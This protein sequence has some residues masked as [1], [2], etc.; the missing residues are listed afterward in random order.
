MPASRATLALMRL[1]FLSVRAIW[2]MPNSMAWLR[3]QQD[4][5]PGSTWR[6]YLIALLI[7]GVASAIRMAFFADLG[8]NTAYLTYYPA[9]VLAALAGGL[10]SGL[11][12]T[13]GSALL[14][15]FWI[16]R[17]YMSF[18][19][20][21]AM[22]T[23]ILSCSMIA[24]IAE[25]MRR[26]QARARQE[27][28]KAEA[29]NLAKSLFLASMN[30]ELRTPLNAIL[31]FTEILRNDSKIPAAQ[32][33][34]L[35]IIGRSGE[36]LLALINDVL[37]MAKIDAGRM[38]LELS[39]FDLGELLHDVVD[40]MQ[41]RAQAKGL[42][43]VLDQTPACPRFVRS[44]QAKLRQILINL[45]GNA[46][47]FTDHGGV[48]L[49]LDAVPMA[50]TPGKNAAQ[51]R[52]LLEVEDSGIGIAAQEQAN[53]YQPFV[54][55]GN[56][57]HQKGTG[58]GLAIT[59]RFVELLAGSIT[60][61][62][63]LGQGSTFRIEL[64]LDIAQSAEKIAPVQRGRVVKLAPGMPKRR[65]LIVEDQPENW[66]L[67][68]QLLEPVGFEV[69]VAENG[70]AGVQAFEDFKPDLIWMD[71]RMPVMDGMQATAQ[72][73]QRP[74]G[75]QVKIIAITASVFKSESERIL[76]AGM[77]GLIRKPYRHEE[78]YACLTQQLGVRFV[79]E[80]ELP[81]DP[82][83]PSE[84]AASL[85]LLPLAGLSPAVRDDLKDA[86]LSLDGERLK[87]AIAQ[88]AVS[89]PDV[90]QALSYHAEQLGYSTILQ[91]LKT[92][93]TPTTGTP[94]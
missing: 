77:D 29:A 65:I 71:I 56:T 91:A 89:H 25:G 18:V 26:A 49:R 50:N 5:A 73:R 40:L 28:E 3:G 20:S 34:T 81:S 45:I 72:I 14:C 93:V 66:Q 79:R 85:G 35:A 87:L 38:T 46:I 32:R 90:A 83:A 15:F 61:H 9:V 58:L 4:E 92:P 1:N 80:A 59:R 67:L 27:K 41:V 42:Q 82:H 44:D 23:F 94:P 78:I 19:E 53:I 13:L 2:P 54:R 10:R 75:Q 52:L 70:L 69:Q 36:H 60:L 7:V 47:K 88:V 57:I 63:T 8:R 51:V 62:S 21:L 12:T 84:A 76:A 37:D 55:V 33:K 16:Q 24:G 48:A 31:G 43:L 17:G 22:A 68:L 30:H 74:G 86:L 64:P 39:A 6:L 11:L